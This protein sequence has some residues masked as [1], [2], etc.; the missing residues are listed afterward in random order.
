MIRTLS[1]PTTLPV[2]LQE[3]K[4]YLKIDHTEEDALLKGLIEAA[5]GLVE[6]ETGRSLLTRTWQLHSLGVDLP[7]GSLRLSLPFPP[8]QS[9]ITVRSVD[10]LARILPKERYTV[11]GERPL[12][13]L[14]IH[15]FGETFEVVYK[16]GYG[17]QKTD[18]PPP[19]RQAIL[20]LVAEMYEQRT[21][22]AT[23]KEHSFVHALLRPYRIPTSLVSF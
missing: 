21:A 20:L 17:E 14:K 7:D 5:S 16:A 13:S 4:D 23:L 9:V 8:L 6:Q 19:L 18:I 11:E 3:V 15:S 1:I 22:T 2:S 12:P 10:P